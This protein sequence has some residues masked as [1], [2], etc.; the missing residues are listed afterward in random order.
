M[1]QRH[2]RNVLSR[3]LSVGI[4]AA[5]LISKGAG[6]AIASTALGFGASVRQ[7]KPPVLGWAQREASL[8]RCTWALGSQVPT[9]KICLFLVLLFYFLKIFGS[10]SWSRPGRKS[11]QVI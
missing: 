6:V 3:T 5:S 11:Q 7:E 4:I 10:N 8:G 2:Y 1:D 9:F